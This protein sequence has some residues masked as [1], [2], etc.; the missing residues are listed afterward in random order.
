M[1]SNSLIENVE[2]MSDDI[3][4]EEDIVLLKANM[5]SKELIESVRL[6]NDGTQVEEFSSMTDFELMPSNELIG[7]IRPVCLK[8]LKMNHRRATS[9]R[10]SHL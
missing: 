2:F 7:K 1:S 5:S 10:Y 9:L 8:S 4:I 6:K 3:C